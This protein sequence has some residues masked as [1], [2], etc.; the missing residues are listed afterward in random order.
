MPNKNHYPFYVIFLIFLLSSLCTYSQERPAF[1]FLR[2]DPTARSSA[3]AGAFETY[4]DDPNIIF[5]NPAGLST[6]NKKQVSA[7]F[8][9]YLLD[10]NF[11]TASFAMKYKNIGWLGAG[12]KYFNYGSFDYTDE[13][14]VTNGTFHANDIM[15]SVGYSNLIYDMVNY[16][17]NV[18]YIVSQIAEYSSNAIAFDLGLLYIIPDQDL[19]I[20]FT[21]N[22]YGKQLV[23][24]ISSKEKLPV[25]VRLGVSKRLEHLPVRLSLSLSNLNDNTIK[26]LD[27]KRLKSFSLGGEFYLSDYVSARI[28]YNNEYRQDLQLGSSIGITGFSAGLGIKFLDKYKFDYS[29]NSLGKIGSTHRFNIGYTFE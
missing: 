2:V 10:I 19:N 24:Y 1:D 9:K 7:T 11:G 18:K 4:T 27:V 17:I 8:G 28:G 12:V 6:I 21:V 26:F 13:N 22:N 15:F 16:G 29:L 3:L 25:D 5:F 14:G 23:A 20:A